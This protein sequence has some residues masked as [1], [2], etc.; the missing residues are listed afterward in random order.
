Q[1]VSQLRVAGQ[2]GA[3]HVGGDD[4]ALHGTLGEALLGAVGDVVGGGGDIAV[5]GAAGDAAEGFG[6]RAE[7]GG[8]EVV[9]E[10]GER[11]RQVGGDAGAGGGRC[12]LADGAGLEADGGGVEKSEAVD[13]AAA[14]AEGFAE[15]LQAGADTEHGAAGPGGA[16]EA[17]VG[18]I[19][20]ASWRE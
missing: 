5:A 11:L 12:D 19:G 1:Q 10:A 8:A 14:G 3:V 17:A 20:R 16:G 7:E 9:L 18:E 6:A 15:D 13:D 2:D 4:A